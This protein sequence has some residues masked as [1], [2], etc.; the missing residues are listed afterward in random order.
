LRAGV[1]AISVS[2]AK[3]WIAAHP[4]WTH[5]RRSSL[6]RGAV[7]V[8]GK[9]GKFLRQTR[10]PA[11]RAVQVRGLGGA[12][13]ELLELGSAILALV[14]VDRHRRTPYFLNSQGRR[15][16]APAAS[17]FQLIRNLLD[18][19]CLVFQY[20]SSARDLLIGLFPVL[21]LD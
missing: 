19:P 1:V 15:Q 18:C 17:A 12:P 6:R 16:R 9:G 21:L 20:L 7:G 5:G 13:Q 8:C 10:L 3:S 11:R 2:T 14:F 4:A